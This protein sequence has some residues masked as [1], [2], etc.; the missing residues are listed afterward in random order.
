MF[1]NTVEKGNGFKQNYYA[2]NSQGNHLDYNGGFR[3]DGDFGRKGGFNGGR[4]FNW[5]DNGRSN[6]GGFC[7]RGNRGSFQA[8]PP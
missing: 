8:R 3:R 4:G 7:G 5:N 1:S 2:A 6:R